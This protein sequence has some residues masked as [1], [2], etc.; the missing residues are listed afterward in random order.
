MK[1]AIYTKFV[2]ES[3]QIVCKWMDFR[4]MLLPVFD[5]VT[6]HFSLFSKLQGKEE[7]KG[8][9]KNAWQKTNWL[10]QNF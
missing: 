4:A 3:L 2:S 10:I 8:L 7:L 6:A 5:H 9:L 1:Q